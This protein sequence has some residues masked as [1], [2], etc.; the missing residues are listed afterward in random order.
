MSLA[1]GETEFVG[2]W[3]ELGAAQQ[4]EWPDAHELARVLETIHELP[5][6]V[7]IDEVD[8]LFAEIAA[9]SRGESFLLFGGDCVESFCDARYAF[10]RDRVS[11]LAE[12]AQIVSGA[13]GV[14]V[15]PIGRMA[16]QYAKPRTTPTETQGG[17]ELP[18]FRG[19]AVNRAAFTLSARTPNP[20]LLLVAHVKA[21][22]VL[23]CM[24]NPTMARRVA[25]SHEAL[26]PGFEGALARWDPRSEQWYGSSAHF[27]WAGERTR[28]LDGAHLEF[29]SEI[30]NPVGC[31][32]GPTATAEEVLAICRKLDPHRT[33][34][35]LTLI[36]RM[37]AG[38]IESALPPIVSAVR[39]ANWQVA[40]VCD[41]MHGNG[42]R[43]TSGVKT[44]RLDDVLAEVAAFATVHQELGTVPAG[45]HLELTHEDVLE[46]VGTA[47]AWA[48]EARIDRQER[49][50]SLCDPRLNGRQAR[51]VAATIGRLWPGSVLPP[52]WN[53]SR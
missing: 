28:Q 48:D 36:T 24:R 21:R 52:T 15:V 5:A 38:S 32:V 22:T 43:T 46:C 33:P 41:P 31:K 30:S 53:G 23:T 37:G 51:A 12:M 47:D 10:V 35:R 40:W 11:L 25:T 16:G 18:A 9:A 27:L 39:D 3:T 34:G 1:A 7:G 2:R 19:P 49:Y 20:R 26:L 50:R 42:L 14:P 44:R 29:L 4:P 45:I 17:I 8:R 6:L 13:L